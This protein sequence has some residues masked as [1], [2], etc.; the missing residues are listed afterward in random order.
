MQNRRR[1]RVQKGIAHTLVTSGNEQ[2][3]VVPADESIDRFI[4]ASRGRN[5]DNPSDRTV[6]APTTQH[7]EANSQGLCNTLTTVQKDNYVC[8]VDNHTENV[9]KFAFRIRKLTELECWL[10]M[11]FPKEAFDKASKV[12]S[13]SRLYEQAGNSIVTN[14]LQRMLIQLLKSVE[15]EGL[16]ETTK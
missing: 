14:C 8:E 12:C 15:F 11:G 10:L 6:G 9:P 1:G 5:P 7:L 16:N 2:A 4:V 3:V 13:K